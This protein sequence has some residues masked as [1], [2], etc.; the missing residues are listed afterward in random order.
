MSA[1]NTDVAGNGVGQIG[2]HEPKTFLFLGPE[3][4]FTHQAAVNAAQAFGGQHRHIE[5]AA[6]QNVP[7]II[8]D[9]EAGLGWGVIAWENSVEGYV[10]PN[11]DAV[12]DARNVAGLARLGI[13]IAFDAFVCPEKTQE[14]RTV[15]NK[16]SI[17]TGSSNSIDSI[18]DLAS[19][20]EG[21]DTR[22]SVRENLALNDITLH[23]ATAH[24]HGLAQ[25]TRFISE[26]DLTPVPSSSNAAACRDVRP[27]QV[28][29]GPSICGSLY[30]LQTLAHNVQD[31]GGAKTDFL[32][33]APRN[34]VR[35]VLQAKR[36][37][38][39]IDFETIIA[40]IPLS[41]GPGVIANLLDA[42]RDEGLNM[43][44]L[45]SRPIKG[46]AGTYSFIITLD[47]APWQPN[48]SRLLHQ[49]VSKGD[50]VKTLAVYPRGEH[51]NPPVD[52]WMLPQG[53]ICRRR[54]HDMVAGSV[55]GSTD[56]DQVSDVKRAK[57]E[58]E[59]LW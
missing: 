29:L 53:G 30:G 16:P 12:I 41:T 58:R 51:P 49:I 52:T 11:L 25:C 28:A 44:S 21:H 20:V 36:E 40:V 7:N 43:T 9:V 13:E 18:E 19:S 14:D 10:V 31:F 38:D 6:R 17:D 2:R 39:V 42:V 47:A 5:L 22:G 32:V 27:G 24:P 48:F 33:V 34:E 50:W 57:E 15:A 4:S 1:V 8:R 45:M 35:R 54:E 46:N 23:E 55:D 59:L 3:G 26:H 37:S 56:T